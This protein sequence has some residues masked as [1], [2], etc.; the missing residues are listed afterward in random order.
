MELTWGLVFMFLSLL[1]L[2]LACIHQNLG[3]ISCQRS[4]L[5]SES[6]AEIPRDCLLSKKRWSQ[7]FSPRAHFWGLLGY[8]LTLVSTQPLCPQPPLSSSDVGGA[9][10]LHSEMLSW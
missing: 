8:S 4:T 6:C 9:W 3:S 7:A 1:L 2:P 10:S 5:F